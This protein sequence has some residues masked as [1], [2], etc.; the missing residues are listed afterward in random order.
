MFHIDD[1]RI[2]RTMQTIKDTLWCNTEIGGL[3]R[4]EN[5]YYQRVGQPPG[6]PYTTGNPWFICTMWYAQYMIA[7]AETH[8]ELDAVLPILEWATQRCLPSGV[9]AEQI[10]PYSG[11][12]ISVSPLTW[13]HAAYVSAVLEYLDRHSEMTLCPECGTPLHFREQRSLRET[14]HRAH[15]RHTHVK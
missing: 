5:D 12:P 14:R 1:P 2:V 4:Y 6:A 9:M 8:E 10:D 7:T 13:S 15:W 11:A 3:A